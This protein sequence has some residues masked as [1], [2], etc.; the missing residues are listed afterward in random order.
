MMN[1]IIIII[2]FILSTSSCIT[3]FIPETDEYRNIIVIEGLLT[4]EER[5]NTIK[6]SRTRPI[7]VSGVSSPLINAFVDIIDDDGNHYIVPEK[8]PGI[9]STDSLVFR[10]VSGRKYKLRVQTEDQIFESDLMLMGEVPPIDSLYA[11]FNFYDDG[12]EYPPLYAYDVFFDSEDPQNTNR[13][14][15]WTY[16]EVWEYHLP[17]HYPPPSKSICWVT[18]HSNDI[19]IKNTSA[20]ESGRI[21]EYP[22]VYLDNRSSEKLSHKYSILLKQYSISEQEYLYWENMKKIRDDIGGLYDPIPMSIK[23]NI[24][25]VNDPKTNVLGFFSV[26]SVAAKR[27]FIKNDTIKMRIPGAYCVTDTLKTLVN[28]SGLGKYIFVLEEIDGVGFL[29]STFPQCADCTLRGSNI[30]PLFWNDDQLFDNEN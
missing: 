9:Y 5:S 28:V 2:T 10:G 25:S 23:G 13:Y 24:H 30:K 26:S 11:K 18:E 17:W 12:Y 1:K 19:I 15:R 3:Q 21:K 20:M 22:L 16:E 27:L 8:R 6:I 4:N 7:D 29:V 14:Y